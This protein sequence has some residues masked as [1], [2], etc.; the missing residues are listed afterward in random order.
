M[1]T[2]NMQAADLLEQILTL[3][4]SGEG[5]AEEKR[6]RAAVKKVVRR[7]WMKTL[8]RER[9]T[10]ELVRAVLEA[11]YESGVGK[12]RTGRGTKTSPLAAVIPDMCAA[13]SQ[14]L[15]E[16]ES[17]RGRVQALWESVRREIGSEEKA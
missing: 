14:S 8:P 2:R 6:V 3:S 7:R 15:Q 10:V 16:T 4:S 1:A 5:D 12:K 13:I 11:F 17:A 9:E